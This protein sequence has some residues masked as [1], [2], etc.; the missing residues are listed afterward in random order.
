MIEFNWLPILASGLVP[1]AVGLL[2]YGPLFGK[3]WMKESDMSIE[4]IKGTNMAV[5]YGVSVIFGLFL[6]VGLLPTVIHQMGIY[7]TLVD[8]G[9][10][11]P[12]GEAYT[13]FNDLMAKYGTNFRTFKHGVLHGLLTSVFFFLPVI[14]NNAL[15]ERKSWRYIFINLGYWAVSAMIMGGIISAWA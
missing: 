8:S 4:K 1:L 12:G 7:S 11:K 14:A 10:D 9:I 5:I 6:A 15:M 2:W 13:I 3:L